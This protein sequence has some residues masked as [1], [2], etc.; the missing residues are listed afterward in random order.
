MLW[1]MI[2]RTEWRPFLELLSPSFFD[3]VPAGALLKEIGRLTALYRKDEA[4]SRAMV[5]RRESFLRAGLPITIAPNTPN[6]TNTRTWNARDRG[7]RILEIYFNQI[8]DD[9]LALLDL[10]S[11]RFTE[12][13]DVLV[14]NPTSILADWPAEFRDALRALYRGFYRANDVL[15]RQGLATLGLAKIEDAIRAQFGA[16]QQDAVRFTQH[17]FQEKFKNVFVRCRET[18]SQI[19]TNFI[20]LGLYLA[21]MYEHLET[22]DEPFDARAAYEAID[23]RSAARERDQAPD[24]AVGETIL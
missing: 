18:H 22:L 7:Q 1:S 4:F 2:K 5:H 17:D 3:V 10:R 13:G 20:S 15:F 9:G 8:F 11:D 23:G 24:P 6:S 12:D 16:G 21:T 19:D 14:W